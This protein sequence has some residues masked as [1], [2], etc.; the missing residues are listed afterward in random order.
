[1]TIVTEQTLTRLSAGVPVPVMIAGREPLREV[2]DK[3]G[4][5][6]QRTANKTCSDLYQAQR[7]RR[8]RHPL[9][10]M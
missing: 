9:R 10:V 1:M 8:P 3:A 5:T 6:E 4:P 2:D 7:R